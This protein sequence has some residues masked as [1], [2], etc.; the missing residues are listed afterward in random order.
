MFNTMFCYVCVIIIICFCVK[1]VMYYWSG[2]LVV[3]SQN[4]TACACISSSE[5]TEENKRQ[6]TNEWTYQLHGSTSIIYGLG[7]DQKTFFTHRLRVSLAW[8]V[9]WWLCD[10]LIYIMGTLLLVRRHW[11]PLV[12]MSNLI[13]QWQVSQTIFSRPDYFIHNIHNRL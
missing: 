5:T 10:R 6:M 11:G 3:Y 13:T 2:K 1:K 8:F 9:F 7:N 4:C 12:T